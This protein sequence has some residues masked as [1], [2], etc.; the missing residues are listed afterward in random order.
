MPCWRGEGE[1][2]EGARRRGCDVG[3]AGHRRI[4]LRLPMEQNVKEE[5]RLRKQTTTAE[6]VWERL[7]LAPK[8]RGIKARSKASVKWRRG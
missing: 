4:E 2:G 6:A 8:R 7:E 5:G 1:E 3:K